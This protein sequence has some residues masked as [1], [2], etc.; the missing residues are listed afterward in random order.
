MSFSLASY[1]DPSNL[2]CCLCPECKAPANHSFFRCK[3]PIPFIPFNDMQ[4]IYCRQH[5]FCFSHRCLF[6]CT[7]EA[8]PLAHPSDDIPSRPSS[9]ASAKK[10][11]QNASSYCIVISVSIMITQQSRKCILA[12]RVCKKTPGGKCQL[13]CPAFSV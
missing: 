2:F 4:M 13:L 1:T 8:R 9:P 3:G 11:P 5:P 10:P 12:L 6:L 7:A